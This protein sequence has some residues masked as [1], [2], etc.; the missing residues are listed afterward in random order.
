VTTA[1]EAGYRLAYEEARRAL[2]DQEALVNEL[3]ARTGVLI[4]SAAVS[5]SLVGGPALA[6]SHG[7]AS[8]VAIGL[9][10]LVGLSLLGLVWP[11]RVW[12]FTIDV[13]DFIAV[14]LEP[15]DDEPLELAAIYRDLA[16]HMSDRHRHNAARL[17]FLMAVLRVAV[18]LLFAG[19]TACVVAVLTTS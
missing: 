1:E 15:D 19:V 10:A 12:S 16:L 17:P 8:W 7:V 6:R 11:R 2:D 14:Y 4:A 3:R 18:L 13:A 5:T 9:F